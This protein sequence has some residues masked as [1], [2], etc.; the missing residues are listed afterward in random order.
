MNSRAS[1]FAIQ[2][3]PLLPL[4]VS[5]FATPQKTLYIWRMGPLRQ[6]SFFV[7][8]FLYILHTRSLPP[9]SHALR[10][11]RL[12]KQALVITVLPIPAVVPVSLSSTLYFCL[13]VPVFLRSIS[14]LV[15]PF[16][17]NSNSFSVSGYF[18]LKRLPRDPEFD[19][20]VV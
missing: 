18:M 13:L 1:R 11:R 12:H 7:S 14:H 17:L 2:V 5:W 16:A 8:V 3:S 20:R 9:L 10:E 19:L 4:S 15:F 6:F